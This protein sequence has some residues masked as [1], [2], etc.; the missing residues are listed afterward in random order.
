MMI[1]HSKTF[2]TF[3]PIFIEIVVKKYELTK[4]PPL[5]KC[6]TKLW[7]IDETLLNFSV[8]RERVQIL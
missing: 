6:K 3:L 1:D 4:N 2:V 5:P 8:R 7:K